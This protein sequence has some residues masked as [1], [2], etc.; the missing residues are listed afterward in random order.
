MALNARKTEHSGAKKGL[1]A[2]WGRKA[3]A[4]VASNRRRRED[5][6]RAITEQVRNAKRE[7]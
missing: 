1:G 4:K 6:K 3:E 2:F 5:G 7:Q